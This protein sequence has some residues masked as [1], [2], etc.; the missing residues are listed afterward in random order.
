MK[1]NAYEYLFNEAIKY[2][3]K[4]PAT[5]K[6]ITELLKKK[7]NSNKMY[8]KI[9]FP[10]DFDKDILIESIISKLD[11]LKIIN[12]SHYLESMFNY[13]VQSF[14][15]VRKIK[16][17]LFQKGFDKNNID[18]FIDQQFQ[19]NPNLE[20]DILKQYIIKKK[21]SDLEETELKKKLY[22]QS[23]SENSIYKI[24]KE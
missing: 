22:L 21:L 5:K 20:I 2:L 13:Y 23:F 17:K 11:E 12:E 16:S 7:I 9:N 6:K 8:H 4:Y 1:K 24:I 3:G 14:F 19:K 18:E 15:S 10:N